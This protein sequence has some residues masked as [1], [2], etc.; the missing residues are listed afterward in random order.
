MRELKNLVANAAAWDPSRFF[1]SFAPSV[2][3]L[4]LTVR[5]GGARL[6]TFQRGIKYP[7]S[8]IS[9]GSLAAI[10]TEL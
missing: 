3:A 4:P 7:D 9:P 5:I 8:A 1:V 2:H 10:R 6:R